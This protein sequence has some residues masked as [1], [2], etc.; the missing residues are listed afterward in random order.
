[1][2]KVEIM[3]KVLAGTDQDKKMLLKFAMLLS[4]K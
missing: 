2:T 4:L 3:E 1:M